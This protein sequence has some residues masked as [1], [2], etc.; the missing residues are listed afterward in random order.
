VGA[1]PEHPNARLLRELFAAF[2]GGDIERIGASFT[3]DVRWT[4]AGCSQ[5]AGEFAGREAVLAQLARSGEL[6]G[7]TYRVAVEHVMASDSHACVLYRG[8][9]SRLGRSLD[10]RH[11]ALYDIADGKISAVRVAPLDQTAFDEFWS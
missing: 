8:T 10:L 7:G 3:E 4:T 9:G 6:S 11:L 1:Q 5:L 2:E